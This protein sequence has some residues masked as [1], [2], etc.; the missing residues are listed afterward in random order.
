MSRPSEITFIETKE[1]RRFVEFCQAC[2]RYRYIGLCY[3]SPGVGKTLS[4]RRYANWDKVQAYQPYRET[5]EAA[6]KEVLGSDTV[7]YTP[8]VVN[9]PAQVERDIELL[10]Q[11]LHLICHEPI[12]REE[13]GKRRVLQQEEKERR[14]RVFQIDWYREPPEKSNGETFYDI[15]MMYEQKRQK[16][17]DPTSLLIVDEADRLKVSTLEQM[18]AIFDQGGSGLVLIGMPG[19][20]RRLARYPQLY[21]RVGFVHQF[22]PLSEAE[23]RCLLNQHWKPDGVSLPAQFA[24]EEALIAILRITGGNFRLLHRLLTQIGRIAEINKLQEVSRPVVEAARES[25]VIGT[26]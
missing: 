15:S 14:D 10:R 13:K 11:R 12:D 3:G 23:T 8:M 17:P 24:D 18:R 7:F 20:E 22:R 16:T 6:L 21:S 25:L 1:Y 19:L 9:S 26:V 5:S 4:A 2:S